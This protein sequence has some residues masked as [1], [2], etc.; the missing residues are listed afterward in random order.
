MILEEEFNVPL[1][2]AWR[3]ITEKELM[4][5]WYFDIAE[6]KP[7]V[8]FKFDFVG[9]EE[10]KPYLHLCEVLEV[11]PLQKLRYS[12]K[13]D[14]YNGIS[15]V[16]FELASHNEKTVVKLIHEGTESFSEP[17]LATDKFRE[18]WEY[19]IHRSLKEF[20]ENGKELRYW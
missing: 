8:G 4:A 5:K 2:I 11:I 10:G 7:E 15:H 1:E 16:T 20:L 9:G 14:G 17:D 6:F 13:Y 18:G 12:W 19:L 3:A